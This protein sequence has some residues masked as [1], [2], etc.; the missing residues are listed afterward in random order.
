MLRFTATLVIVF[1]A[2]KE[3]NYGAET[4]RQI[5]RKDAVGTALTSGFTRR[6]VA[7]DLGPGASTL[8]KQ[9]TAHRNTDAVLNEDIGL[10]Q[11]NN[12]LRRENHIIMNKRGILQ[13]AT[14][15]VASQKP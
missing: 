11:E 14:V 6:Q 1:T 4:H 15:F 10:A 9:I 2:L 8:N 13:K 5:A 7:D 12:Q 3:T